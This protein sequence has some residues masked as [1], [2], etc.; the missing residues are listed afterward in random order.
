LQDELKA[1]WPKAEKLC[2][3]GRE[4]MSTGHPQSGEIAAHVDSLQKHWKELRALVE[5]RKS[6]LEEA[7]EAYQFYADANEAESW[8]REKLPLVRSTDYGED[9]PSAQA[10]LAR[11][12]DL[13]GQIRA[14][15]GDLQSL[16]TQADRL[17]ASGVTSLMLNETNPAASEGDA[18]AKQQPPDD[19]WTEEIRMVP[20]EFYEEEAYER[21][22]YRT[23]TEERLVPQVKG[24]YA[25]EGQGMTLAKG[26]VFQFLAVA[27]SPYRVLPVGWPYHM[28]GGLESDAIRRTAFSSGKRDPT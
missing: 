20:E 1:R 27:H 22:E 19:E 25:F 16:N 23:V 4:L 5:Q 8:L 18:A 12:R 7:A 11:H 13:E 9:E 17:V 3:A 2:D 6:R 10:L 15:E 28:T 14:Y 21:T 24:L 26:E